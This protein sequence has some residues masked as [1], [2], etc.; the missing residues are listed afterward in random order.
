MKILFVTP[1]APSNIGAAMKFTKAIIE[2]LA[3][4]NSI[5]VVYFKNSDE[6]KYEPLIEGVRI[7]VKIDV[8]TLSRIKG[9]I[10]RPFGHPVFSV[11][12]SNSIRK[13]IAT[14]MNMNHY[15][16]L[17]LDHS[18]T[19]I[20][21]LDYPDV[22]KI[23]MSHDVM[24]QRIERTHGKMI[25]WLTKKTEKKY[26]SQKN[27]YI[28]TF[29]TKDKQIIKNEYG[30]DS[31]VTC[32]NIDPLAYKVIPQNVDNQFVFFGQWVRA[33]NL[34]GLEWFLTQVLPETPINWK[35]FIIGRGLPERIKELI[36][37]DNRVVY[38]GFV[39]NPYEQIANCKAMLSPLFSGAGVKFK[40]L[41][42]LACGTP[43]IGTE[44]AFEGIP[45]EYD[46]FMIKANTID[47][48]VYSMRNLSFTREER[49]ALK[50]KFIQSYVNNG[51]VEFINNFRK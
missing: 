17:F 21:G 43:V 7:L 13:K 44:I 40:V 11:R 49:I 9:I 23:L 51:L 29:S 45:T 46:K 37:K 47:E 31:Y 12:F 22:P 15:D 5:D 1:F 3:Q 50:N 8:S 28:Y 33:D 39:D 18:Q 35:F 26:M 20:Y 41:E 19:F 2:N 24:C 14:Y 48:Y 36:T 38:K 25:T 27:S 34:D 42:S 32:G 30:I 16:L 4:N 6:S 10:Q